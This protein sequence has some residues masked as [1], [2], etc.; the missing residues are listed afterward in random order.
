[1]L[2]GALGKDLL[3][4]KGQD[5]FA[6]LGLLCEFLIFV[7]FVWD[8]EWFYPLTHRLQEEPHTCH[9]VAAEDG[10]LHRCSH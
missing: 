6:V 9:G 10:S 5:S 1:M 2:A 7:Y 4:V 8:T 3:K